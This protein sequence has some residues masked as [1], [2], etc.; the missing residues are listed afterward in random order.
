MSS[1]IP[2]AKTLVVAERGRACAP[3]RRQTTGTDCCFTPS[4][5]PPDRPDLATYSQQEQF[6]LGNAPT[7]DSPDILSNFWNPFRLMPE[8]TVTVRNL[9]PS[10]T[11]VNG[12]VM[13]STATFGIGNPRTPLGSQLVTLAPGQQTNL[14][15]P[16]PQAVLNAAEQRIAL[17]VRLVHPYDAKAINNLGSQLLADAYTSKV[18]RNITVQF[19]LVN[20][21]SAAQHV[22]LQALPNL[23]SATVTPVN[24]LLGP[25]QQ[26]MATLHMLVPA[27][28]HG[29]AAAP[30]RADVTIVGRDGVGALID[31]LTYVIWVDD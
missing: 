6:A 2:F 19:P 27:A 29:T 12:Q 11:A 24:P 28:L 7:W 26:V 15:F 8:I 18:G 20:P 1:P 5:P 4:G 9:S 21:Q 13:L 17:N 3:K 14:V 31:G 16:L 22:T 25:A 23:L 30:V 10:A